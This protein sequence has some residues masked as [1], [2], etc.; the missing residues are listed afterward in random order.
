MMIKIIFILAIMWVLQG[1][2]TFFQ[3]KNLQK[4]IKEMKKAGN[5]GIGSRKGKL[6]PGCIFIIASDEKGRIINAKKMSG[7]SV[8]S[9]FKDIDLLKG[10]YLDEAHYLIEDWSKAEKTAAEEALN[11]LKI[12]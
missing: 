12:K 1:I 11:M 7:I 9:R 4:E 3:V 5:I 8:F 10:L 6:G 2:L